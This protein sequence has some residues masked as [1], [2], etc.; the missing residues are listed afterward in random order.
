MFVVVLLLT[1]VVCPSFVCERPPCISYQLCKM[2][3]PMVA[4]SFA[5]A[6]IPVTTE[7]AEL[8]QTYT[9]KVETTNWSNTRPVAE[10][11]VVMW[12]CHVIQI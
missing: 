7:L 11:Q 9:G 10:T 6:G 8:F 4:R 2:H 12:E 1:L 5:P 3:A